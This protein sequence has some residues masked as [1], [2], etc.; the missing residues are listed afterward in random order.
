MIAIC[1][2]RSVTWTSAST[3]RALRSRGQLSSQVRQVWQASYEMVALALQ[4]FVEGR[5][6]DR[7]HQHQILL[8]WNDNPVYLGNERWGKSTC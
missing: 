6:I 7:A 3:F 4:E 8:E 1:A 5:R 2:T